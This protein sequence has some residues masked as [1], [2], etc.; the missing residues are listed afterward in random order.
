MPNDANTPPPVP[1]GSPPPLRS[2][3]EVLSHCPRSPVFEQAGPS[4]QVSVVDFSSSLD[5][6]DFI[7]DTSRDVEFDKRLFGDLN[8]DIFGPPDDC[9]VITISGSDEEEEA[10]E[11]TVADAN[12]APS[13]AKKSLTPVAFAAID[14]KDLGKIHDD[15]SDDLALK[16]DMGSGSSS[17]DKAGSP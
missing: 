15:N 6:E 16:Q 10:C 9:K 2:S 5:E 13:T 3:S 17:G 11:E 8:C 7:A 12:V 14:D 1:S 4:K